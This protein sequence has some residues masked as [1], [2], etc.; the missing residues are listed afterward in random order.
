MKKSHDTLAYR[1]SII[2]T[3]FNGGESFTAKELAEEFNVSERTI[4]RDINDRLF[5]M[6]IEKNSDRYSMQSYALGKLSFKDIKSFA[7]LSGVSH[8]YPELT[9]EFITDI[10][11]VKLN[12]A[13]LVKNQSFEDIGDKK[14]WFEILSA[15]IVKNSPV[16]FVYADKQREVNP[17]KFVS[18]NGIWYLLAEQDGKLKNFTFSKIKKFIWRDKTKTFTPKKE[19]LEQIAK[20]DTNWF[21]DELIEVT[22]QIDAK[23][24]DYFLR[25]EILPNKKIVEQNDEYLVVSTKVSYDDEVL[26]L[27]KY[28]I[29][30]IRIISPIY[31]QERLEEVLKE[32]INR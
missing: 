23:A 30:Y 3:K 17:Y 1:L 4:Q 21:S 2:L 5:F 22:L 20:N 29:P 27:V 24:K 12:T 26:R 14:E 15:A 11:N 25:K 32:Y 18:N 8:L 16:C 31:L 10:L 6:P 19:F 7:T 13:Y 28:W 9:N